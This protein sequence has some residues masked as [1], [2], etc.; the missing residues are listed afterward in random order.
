M[1]SK[2]KKKIKNNGNEKIEKFIALKTLFG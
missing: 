2:V 1:F